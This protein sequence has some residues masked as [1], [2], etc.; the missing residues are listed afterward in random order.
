MV[1]HPGA[2]AVIP[3]GVEGTRRGEG[4]T[5]YDP[6]AQEVKPSVQ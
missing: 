5:A 4:A 6:K 2:L 1:F 3:A